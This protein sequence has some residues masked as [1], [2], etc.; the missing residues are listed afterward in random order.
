MIVIVTIL[1]CSTVLL[2]TKTLLRIKRWIE[3]NSLNYAVAYGT[4]SKL[5]ADKAIVIGDSW[6]VK[7]ALQDCGENN[8]NYYTIAP[9]S[10]KNILTI[11]QNLKINSQNNIIV[12]FSDLTWFP[13]R[14]KNTPFDINKRYQPKKNSW[15]LSNMLNAFSDTAFLVADLIQKDAPITHNYKKYYAD[16]DHSYSVIDTLAIQEFAD[17]IKTSLGAFKIVT[18]TQVNPK[19]LHQEVKEK[20]HKIINTYESFKSAK[21]ISSENWCLI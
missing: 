4:L 9:A 19:N 10:S 5:S 18:A 13:V 14:T 2:Q 16:I 17:F 12:Q 7:K 6:F 15:Q 20:R 11:L 1:F 8:I 3:P 21:Y